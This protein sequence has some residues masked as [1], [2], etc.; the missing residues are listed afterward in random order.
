MP[1]DVF[2]AYEVTVQDQR[3]ADIKAWNAATTP[4]KTAAVVATRKAH[5]QADL[6]WLKAT[7]PRQC[8]KILYDDLVLYDNQELKVM[9][10]WLAG[11][12]STIN[13]VDLPAI[14]ATW[15]RLSGEFGD[16]VYACS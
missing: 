6:A 10:D 9:N 12:Y 3:V 5:A 13:N 7:T 4:A 15:D 11:R 2:H 14:N 16:A 8:Y 1:W